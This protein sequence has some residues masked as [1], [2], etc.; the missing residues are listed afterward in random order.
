M[1]TTLPNKINPDIAKEREAASFN[2]EEFA[3]WF[4]EGAQ[5]LKKQ[6]EIVEEIFTDPEFDEKTAPD[7]L[8]YQ[9]QYDEAIKRCTLLAKKLEEMQN[10]RNP[11]GS[12]IYPEQLIGGVGYALM[13][14]G[15]PFFLHFTMFIP[16]IEKQGN[17]EQ[18]E[19][20]L[21]LAKNC[22]ILGTYAQTEL[23]HGTF[24]R[25]IQTRAEYDPATEEFILNSPSKT[26]YKWW[27]GA[28]G[29]TV[30]Y[31]IVV[32]QLYI[33]DKHHGIQLF[34][35]QLR[36]EET[37]MPLPG[38]D[39]GDIGN[40]LGLRGINNGYVGFKN[41]RIPRMNMLMRFAQVD[42]DGTFISSPAAVLSYWTMV[43][44]RV[45][46]VHQS[47]GFLTLG[48]TIATRYAA[49]RRQGLIN[50]KDPEHQIL[51]HVTQQ[52]KLF[53]EISKGIAF[54][55]G[56][57][58]LYEMYNQVTKEINEGKFDRLAEVHALSACLKSISTT[59][60]SAG[61][62]TLRLACGGHGYTMASNLPNLYSL[63][64]AAS[65]YEGENTVLLLQ[66]AR[67]LMKS[68]S[69][70][71]KGDKL[72]PTVAYIEDSLRLT[73]G[74][75]KW[76]YSFECMVKALQFTAANKVCLAYNHMA[77]RKKRGMTPE[78][79][80]DSTSIELVQAADLHGRSFLATTAWQKLVDIGPHS[81]SLKEVLLDVLELY[82][83][84]ACLRNMADILRFIS[85]TEQ[86][87]KELQT[88]LEQVLHR[89]RPNAVAIVDGFDYHDRIL[90]SVLGS[91]DGNAYERIFDAAQKSPLNKVPVQK[92]FHTY[93]KPFM[94][95]NM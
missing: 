41:V 93:L 53:P 44:V 24:I 51:D 65:T 54:K 67:F 72:P 45:L 27:P 3:C 21:P 15:A 1:P 61:V 7:Y 86:D 29:H 76:N 17:S 43:S 19:K 57:N 13:P 74:F 81:K 47:S 34:L 31:A 92:S 89:I 46:I 75:P 56:A 8:S 68:W 90:N 73:N 84:N 35:V 32:A 58:Y 50:P 80:A 36:D 55:L 95:S 63:A 60:S 22:K 37:H 82:L 40:K 14:Y 85:L 69:M 2:I 91:Y 77:E 42:P 62:E 79:A 12:D 87:L 66:T 94:K 78:E 52:L 71:M 64:T 20:W 4:H 49:V 25:G 33:K 23:S 48:S 5:K 59:D 30:N 16:T 6:R 11:G 83:V 9:D 38:V 39:V 18:V 10:R 88:K 28:M 70:A 26:A